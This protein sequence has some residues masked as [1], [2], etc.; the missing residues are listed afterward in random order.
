MR[1]FLLLVLTLGAAG[2]CRVVPVDQGGAIGWTRGYLVTPAA[3][4][5]A[6]LYLWIT[7][8]TSQ[9]D[10]VIGVRTPVAA[11]AEVHRDMPM[12]NGMSHM[13]PVAELSVPAHDTLRF[14][15]G[16]LHI[17]VIDLSRPIA[18]GDSARV[19][20]TFRRAGDVAGWARVIGYADVDTAVVQPARGGG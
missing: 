17:M 2:A 15:P 14:A 16:G 11:R 13:T 9:A 8:P 18:R 10:T 12:G 3:G 19:T 5:P 1:R 4:S 20:V 6:V 7:N